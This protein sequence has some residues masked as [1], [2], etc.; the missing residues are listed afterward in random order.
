MSGLISIRIFIFYHTL[1]QVDHIN[2][3]NRI[4]NFVINILYKPILYEYKVNQLTLDK[5]DIT[6]LATIDS[7]LIYL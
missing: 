4:K 1:L 7:K 2:G 6:N 3:I 5:N